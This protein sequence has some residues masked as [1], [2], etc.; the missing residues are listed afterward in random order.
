MDVAMDREKTEK[1]MIMLGE[2]LWEAQW[3]IRSR[4]SSPLKVVGKWNIHTMYAMGAAAQVAKEMKQCKINIFGIKLGLD[5]YYVEIDPV[6][7]GWH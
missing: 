4:H 2:S 1:I 3:S 7:V 5:I 6:T